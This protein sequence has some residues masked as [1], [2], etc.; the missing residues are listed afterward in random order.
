MH[1]SPPPQWSAS[2]WLLSRWTL[3]LP[4]L[5]VPMLGMLVG[6][7]FTLS[8]WLGDMG[9]SAAMLAWDLVNPWPNS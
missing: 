9:T 3:V 4:V 7:C 5:G 1:P 8:L 2:G 6:R